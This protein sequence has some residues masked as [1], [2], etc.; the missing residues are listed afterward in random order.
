M[1][2]LIPMGKKAKAASRILATLHSE[3]KDA[4]LNLIA[5][6]IEANANLILA[7]NEKDIV[8]R[9]RGLVL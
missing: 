8:N 5:D 1:I 6:E 7:E 3:K 4:V 2:D 9:D